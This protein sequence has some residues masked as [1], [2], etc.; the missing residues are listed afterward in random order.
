M[1][2]QLL[3]SHRDLSPRHSRR[4]Q[5]SSFVLLCFGSAQAPGPPSAQQHCP[6]DA[7]QSVG[8]T[9]ILKREHYFWAMVLPSPSKAMENA[10]ILE[11][12]RRSHAKSVHLPHAGQHEAKARQGLCVPSPEPAPNSM[13]QYFTCILRSFQ[14]QP[15]WLVQA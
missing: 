7:S 2:A 5:G 1:R 10:T 11:E 12:G 8:G 15:A 3:H 4:A 6:R 13:K 14:N 9:N